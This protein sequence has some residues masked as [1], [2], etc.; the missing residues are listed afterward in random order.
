VA[1]DFLYALYCKF[2]RDKAAC[3]KWLHP[4]FF[5]FP[6]WVTISVRAVISH[7]FDAFFFSTWGRI[8]KAIDVFV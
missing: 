1:P 8:S 6:K 3:V 4:W 2:F 5:L 7:L